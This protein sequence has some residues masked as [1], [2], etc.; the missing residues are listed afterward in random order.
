M[1]E[2][3]MGG[4]EQ[5]EQV[6]VHHLLPLFQRG[7]QDGAEE[8]DPS[9]VDD[10]VQPPVLV[11]RAFD[12]GPGLIPVGDVCLEHQDPALGADPL[13]QRLEAVTPPGGNGHR[14]PLGGQGERGR[15]PDP[16]RCAGDEGNRVSQSIRH[17]TPLLVSMSQ[18]MHVAPS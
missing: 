4:V 15:L 1:G 2:R 9:V 16:A 13:G 14:R 8:H 12:H 18:L 7:V 11:H 5:P 17:S 10:R 3:S 6:Q